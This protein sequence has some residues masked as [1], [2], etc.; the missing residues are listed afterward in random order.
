M[1]GGAQRSVKFDDPNAS[2]IHVLTQIWQRVLRRSNISPVETFH[3]LGGGDERA[4]EIF[5]EIAQALGRQLPT[6]TIHYATTIAALAAVLEQPGLPKFPPFVKLRAGSEKTP[7]LIAHGLGGRASFTELARHIHT[8]HPVYGIQAK[9][10]DGLEEPFARIEDMAAFYLDELEKIQSEGPYILIG[11]SFGGLVA[12]EMAQ[13]LAV[14]GGN[15]ALLAL[16]DSYPH[17]RYLAP[18]Q[19]I[20][21]GIR[22]IKLHASHLMREPTRAAL[23]QVLSG[24]KDRLHVAERQKP[25]MLRGENSPLSLVRTIERV[26]QNDLVALKRYRPSFY[27]GKIRFIRPAV[28]T[29]LPSDPVAVWNKLAAEVE[30][31][32][33]PGDHLGMIA[34]HFES[35]AAVLTRYVRE[36]SAE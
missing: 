22:R 35:L 33:V 18:G 5:A 3:D 15:V 14:Q 10:V 2:T 19:R 29:F 4:D 6:A 21:L 31:E 36:A 25:I 26:K 27:R 34:D 20:E 11:Y 7:V 12:L 13:R 24:F 30:V 9:G 32:T 17:P 16:V 23:A 28:P 1:I 8:E